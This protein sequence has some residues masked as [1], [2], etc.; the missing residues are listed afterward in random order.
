MAWE[1]SSLRHRIQFTALSS[2]HGQIARMDASWRR[3]M[4]GS[5]T[6]SALARYAVNY[7]KFSRISSNESC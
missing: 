1:S 4:P 3:H 7:L 2:G 5:A 6:E